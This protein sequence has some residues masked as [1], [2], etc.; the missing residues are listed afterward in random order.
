MFTARPDL[1]QSA[2][3][4]ATGLARCEYGLLLHSTAA[5]APANIQAAV[6]AKKGTLFT[7]CQAAWRMMDILLL[8]LHALLQN[9]QACC[10]NPDSDNQS[11]TIHDGKPDDGVHHNKFCLI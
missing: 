8:Q 6:L 4:C 11:H 10:A 2:G 5:W 9:M 1:P 7:M 3:P